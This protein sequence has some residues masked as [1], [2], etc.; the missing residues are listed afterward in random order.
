MRRTLA[1]AILGAAWL[2]A[3]AIVLAPRLLAS[4]AAGEARLVQKTAAMIYV[5]A[6]HLCHQKPERSFHSGDRSLP[7]CARCTGLYLSA[8]LGLAFV[9]VRPRRAAR[10][11]AAPD[12]AYHRW[13]IAI[14]LALVPTVLSVAIEQFTGMTGNVSRALTA[15]PLGAIVAALVGALLTAQSFSP[16]DTGQSRPKTGL[17]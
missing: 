5:A 13:R 15:A 12:R 6:G 9:L 14:V 16:A 3:V 11:V 8:P 17:T 1:W 10:D 7:V 2:W 4:G